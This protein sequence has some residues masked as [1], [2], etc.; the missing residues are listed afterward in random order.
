MT[1]L[2]TLLVTAIVCASIPAIASFSLLGRYL[3]PQPQL[4]IIVIVVW[5][6]ITS[7]MFFGMI[8]DERRCVK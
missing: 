2:I 3:T 1:E 7:I 4:G 5:G 6:I 8:K